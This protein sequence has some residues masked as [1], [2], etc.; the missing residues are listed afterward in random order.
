MSKFGIEVWLRGDFI[1]I[2]WVSKYSQCSIHVWNKNNGQI[3]M[4]VGNENGNAILNIVYGNDHFE[5][6]HLFDNDSN[7]M[8]ISRNTVDNDRKNNCTMHV[9]DTNDKP[10]KII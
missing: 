1:T 2:Y 7:N 5:P 9:M 6:T 3:M 10:K 8:N 4:K